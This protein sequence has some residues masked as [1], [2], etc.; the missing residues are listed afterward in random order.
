MKVL[1]GF[2]LWFTFQSARAQVPPATL[3]PVATP[4]EM[5]YIN[6]L[7][8]RLS[9]AEYWPYVAG[10]AFAYPEHVLWGFLGEDNSY[11]RPTPA[12]SAA[13]DCAMQSYNKLVEL[14]NNPP[15]ELITLQER[16]A[17]TAF[18]L[19]TDDYSQAAV[20]TQ[21]RASK[22]W[23]WNSGEKNYAAGFWKWEAKVTRAGECLTPNL[24]QI[25]AMLQQVLA[26]FPPAG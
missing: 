10:E 8:F 22:M 26:V 24:T 14:M 2:A 7:G 17:T 18:Y 6:N 5:T 15:A 11:G 13:Q 21:E 1:L 3:S 25:P 19:W 20:G 9:G 16:G 4:E 12:T 23:H